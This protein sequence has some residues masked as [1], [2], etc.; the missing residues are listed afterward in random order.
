MQLCPCSEADTFI[1]LAFEMTL[2]LTIYGHLAVNLI[3]FN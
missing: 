2:I 3:F 1:F